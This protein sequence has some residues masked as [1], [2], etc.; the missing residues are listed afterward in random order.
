MLCFHFTD[1]QQFQF[2]FH[3]HTYLILG[4]LIVG[5]GINQCLLYLKE[6]VMTVAHMMQNLRHLKYS[7]QMRENNCMDAQEVW[8]S[9]LQRYF[10]Q[11]SDC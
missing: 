1:K 6:L 3:T 11:Y 9:E 2:P 7:C 4:H 5:L 10:R 8:R